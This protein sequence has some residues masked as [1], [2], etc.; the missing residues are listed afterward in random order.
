E[1]IDAIRTE[2]DSYRGSDEATRDRL[3]AERA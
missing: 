3:A 1:L 2:L